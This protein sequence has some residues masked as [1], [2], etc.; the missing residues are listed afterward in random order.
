[1]AL[2]KPLPS[3]LKYIFAIQEATKMRSVFSTSK[4]D[5]T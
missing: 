3:L 2:N 5:F 1:M 4:Q